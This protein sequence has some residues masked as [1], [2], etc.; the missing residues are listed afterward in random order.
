[1]TLAVAGKIVAAAE[2]DLQVLSERLADFESTR[3][4]KETSVEELYARFPNMAREVEQEIK[5][6]KWAQSIV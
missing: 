4:T 2:A 3:I 5:E 6:H 1:M